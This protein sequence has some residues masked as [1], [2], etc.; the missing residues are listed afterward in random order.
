MEKS[1]DELANSVFG[2]KKGTIALPPVFLQQLGVAPSPFVNGEAK[3]SN[4]KM[5]V[6]VG[7]QDDQGEIRHRSE[8]PAKGSETL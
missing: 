7:E 3:T 5:E 6:A 2:E 1:K 4:A 8:D